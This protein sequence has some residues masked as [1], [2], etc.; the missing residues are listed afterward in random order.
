MLLCASVRPIGPGVDRV[1]LCCSVALEP[2]GPGRQGWSGLFVC[3]R[4]QEFPGKLEWVFSAP[5]ATR[6]HLLKVHTD[7]YLR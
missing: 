3:L 1:V 5:P 6:E 4:S 7:Q 2:V